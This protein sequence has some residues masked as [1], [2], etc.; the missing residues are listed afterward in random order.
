LQEDY[1]RKKNHFTSS[2]QEMIC[3][4][5][6]SRGGCKNKGRAGFR[7]LAQSF[8]VDR[9]ESGDVRGLQ[10]LGALRHFEFNGLSFVQRLVTLGLNR[11]E[12]YEDVLAG[13]A[14]D[15][16]KALASIEPLYCTLFFH[17]INVSY[18][19]LSYLVTLEG[20]EP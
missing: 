11:R 3:E 14:L 12:V 8:K 18:S 16:S 5:R 15:E 13:L 6:E 4:G 19:E 20:L 17:G 1:L 2:L 9:L 10:A 7:R